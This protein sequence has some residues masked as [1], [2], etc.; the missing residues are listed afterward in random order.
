MTRSSLRACAPGRERRGPRRRGRDRGGPRGRRAGGGLGLL[1]AA[2]GR[3]RSHRAEV[4]D[5][6]A[7]RSRQNRE[8]SPCAPSPTSSSATRCSRRSSTSVIVLVGLARD[9]RPAGAAVPA[10]RELLGRHHHGLHGRQRRDRA[11]LPDHPDRARR[12]GHRRR[13]PRRVGQPRR[14]QHRH[15]APEANHSTTAALAEVTARLQQVRSELPEE[16]EPPVV[17]VQRADRPYATFY[18]SFTSSERSVAGHH[19]LPGAHG[20]AAARH[21]RGRPARDQQRGRPPDRHAR[22]DRPRPPGRAQPLARRRARARSSA[23]TTSP[24]SARPR[25]TWCRSTCWPTPTCARCDEFEDLIVADRDG[26]LVRLSRRGARRARRRGGRPGRQVQRRGERLPRRLAAGRRQRDRGRRAPA[27]RD[28]AH[29]PDAAGGHRD[30]PGVGRHDVHAR[31]A[32]GDHEDAGRD[33]PDRRPG[34]CSCSWARCARRSCRWS[35][36]RSRWSAR[37]S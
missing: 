23:T 7:A 9:Q 26:A 6:T 4:V 16:A 30:A 12:V 19:R 5:A 28:G 14:R 10:D 8:R 37:R 20:A 31:R 17:E 35:P 11:R 15:R 18:L 32:Q 24:P 13:R 3:A 29:P 21:P 1:Q 25:A 36:C 22:L 33:D 34:R 27:R 2:R